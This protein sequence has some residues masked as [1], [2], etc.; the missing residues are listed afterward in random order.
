MKS[1]DRMKLFKNNHHILN[2][3][4]AL[5]AGLLTSCSSN[6]PE[7]TTLPVLGEREVVEREVN[8]Q[9]VADT[10][11]PQIPDFAFINQDS[12]EVTN[13]TFEGKVYVADFFFTSCPTI[14]P[15][16]KTQMLR[17]YDKFKDNQN[18]AL[19]SHTIDPLHDSVAVLKDYASRLNVKTDKWHFVTGEKDSIYA[20]AQ[21]YLVTAMEDNQE[22]GGFLHSGAFVLVDED[23]HIRGVYD[24]TAPAEVDRLLNDIPVLLK[25]KK[26]G[27]K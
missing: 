3:A 8:G 1:T 18:V 20:I 2:T 5:F 9:I 23:R 19:L 6:D 24:G 16:M 10:L 21:K 4:L 7:V 15:K 27:S 25:E 17:V 12:Q 22:A 11:Y 14:C 13:Q 26:N